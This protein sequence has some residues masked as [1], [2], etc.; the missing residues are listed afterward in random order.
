M[1]PIHYALIL[2]VIVNIIFSYV[3]LVKPAPNYN[4]QVDSLLLVNS[5]LLKDKTRDSLLAEQTRKQL[6]ALDSIIKKKE[7]DLL[8]IS[9]KYTNEKNRIHILDAD[10]QLLLLSRNIEG[11]KRK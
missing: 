7:A 10:D 11:H 4:K 2:S 5:F 9:Q 1:K 6:P 8:L 3:F